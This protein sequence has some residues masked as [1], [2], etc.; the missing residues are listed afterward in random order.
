MNTKLV[1]VKPELEKLDVEKTLSG[2]TFLPEEAFTKD[3]RPLDA[4]P[5]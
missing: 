1:W 3:G 2:S 4:G 5:S